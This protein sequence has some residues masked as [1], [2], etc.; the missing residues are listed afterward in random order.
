MTQIY[1]NMSFFNMKNLDRPQTMVNSEY[2]NPNT[3]VMTTKIQ[4]S[5]K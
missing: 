5:I 4:E 2:L 1:G 3:K